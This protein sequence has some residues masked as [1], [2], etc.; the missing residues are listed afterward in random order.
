M[1]GWSARASAWIAAVGVI[2]FVAR[3]LPLKGV[4]PFGWLNDVSSLLQYLLAIP[5]ALALHGILRPRHPGLAGAATVIGISG[6]LAVAVLQFLLLAQVL[7]FDQ[8]GGP[9][10]IAIL[11]VGVWLVATGYLLRSAAAF[12]RSLLFSLLAVPYFGYPVWAF[13]LSRRLFACAADPARLEATRAE[14]T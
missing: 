3:F 11:V 9:V 12:R 13:W 4:I 7:T 6:M 8:Q 5:V 1:G 14:L 2:C 10:S